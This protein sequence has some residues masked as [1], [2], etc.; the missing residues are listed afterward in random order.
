M[1]Y[2]ESSTVV[3][4][5]IDLMLFLAFPLSPAG[6]SNTLEALDDHESL[7]SQHSAW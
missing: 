6:L 1:I 3:K 5:V 7:T 2:I 4:A